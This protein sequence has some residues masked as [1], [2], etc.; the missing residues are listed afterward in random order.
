MFGTPL[1]LR[2]VG[3]DNYTGRDLYDLIAK[4][5]R[6]FVPTPA[7]TFLIDAPGR[8]SVQVRDSAPGS[9]QD[10]EGAQSQINSRRNLQKT[11]TDM[12]GVSAGQVPRYGF[13]LRIATR[14]G[15]RCGLCPWYQC[16]VGCVVP[17]DD[18]QTVVMCGDSIVIDWHFAVDIA[19]SG[20]G[21]RSHHVEQA[22]QNSSPFRARVPGVSVKNHSSCG[23]GSKQKGY[24]GA[25][26]LED[27]LDAFA[28][29]ER[30]PEVRSPTGSSVP[31]SCKHCLTQCLLLPCFVVDDE[32]IL[33]QVQRF[34]CPDEA[35]ELMATTSHCNNSFE[36]VSIH[37]AYA[38]KITRLRRLPGRRA[39]LVKNYGRR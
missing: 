16:C 25:I 38:Q 8:P 18:S 22:P 23:S 33:L 12:E 10:T 2:V 13:V 31:I 35:D 5:L 9:K 14:D 6:N 29:E 17:D 24:A 21:T 30:I 36:A 3:L 37:S 11:T 32:G 7:L 27:C 26:T 19:T 28:K 4:R 39:G 1:L 20:F 34:P 15:R